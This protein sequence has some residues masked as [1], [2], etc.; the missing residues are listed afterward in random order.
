M[1]LPRLGWVLGR[2]IVIGAA[3]AA[4]V[5]TGCGTGEYNNRLSATV[6]NVGR[7]AAIE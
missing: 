7:R 4:V 6:N 5:G 1:S 3:L 2:G